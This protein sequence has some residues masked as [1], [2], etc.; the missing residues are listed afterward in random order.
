MSLFLY[1]LSLLVISVL[2]QF[3]YKITFSSPNQ[4]EDRIIDLPRGVY[5]PIT[6]EII[7]VDQ[8]ISTPTMLDLTTTDPRFHL[9]DS[10][11]KITTEETRLVTTFLGIRC[12]TEFTEEE[13]HGG[14]T[15]GITDVNS[16]ICDYEKQTINV[17][18]AQNEFEVV[19]SSVSI[20]KLGFGVFTLAKSL[21]FTDTIEVAFEHDVQHGSFHIDGPMTIFPHYHPDTYTNIMTKY[22][23]DSKDIDYTQIHITLSIANKNVEKCYKLSDRSTSF[24]VL[25]ED[26]STP[27]NTKGKTIPLWFSTESTNDNS[28]YVHSINNKTIIDTLLSCVITDNSYPYPSTADILAQNYTLNND[29]MRFFRLFFGD[30]VYN[31]KYEFNTLNRYIQYKY[32]CA[33]ENNR[34]NTSE[35][36]S[37]DFFGSRRSINLID[38]IEYKAQCLEFNFSSIENENEFQEKLQTFTYTMLYRNESSFVENSC[39][40]VRYNSFESYYQEASGHIALL[41]IYPAGQCRYLLNNE[42][43][44]KNI[45]DVFTS[46]KDKDNLKAKLQLKSEVTFNA[47]TDIDYPGNSNETMINVRL[48]ENNKDYIIVDMEMKTSNVRS[49]FKCEYELS[50]FKGDDPFYFKF[51]PEGQPAVIM[52]S[53]DY[54]IHND[55]HIPYPEGTENKLHS[56]N[57]KCSYFPDIR[58]LNSSSYSFSYM[59]IMRNESTYFNC[60]NEE[61]KKT[62]AYC[63]SNKAN[64]LEYINVHKTPVYVQTLNEDVKAFDKV[65]FEFKE[66]RIKTMLRA[67]QNETNM[68]D[69]LKYLITFEEYLRKYNCIQS[70]NG[71]DLCIANKKEM[72]IKGFEKYRDTIKK[73]EGT[74]I[75]YFKTLDKAQLQDVYYGILM[76]FITMLNNMDSVQDFQSRMLIKQLTAIIEPSRGISELIQE[77]LTEEEKIL[78]KEDL[79]LLLLNFTLGYNDLITHCSRKGLIA[80]DKLDDVY[81]QFTT[82]IFENFIVNGKYA[83]NSEKYIF[84]YETNTTTI[85]SNSNIKIN[86]EVLDKETQDAMGIVGYSFVAYNEFEAFLNEAN[87]SS[88]ADLMISVKPFFNNNTLNKY[89]L[90]IINNKTIKL[91]FDLSQVNDV[92]RFNTCYSVMYNGSLYTDN[93]KTIYDSKK[94]QLTCTSTMFADFIIGTGTVSPPEPIPPEDN[95]PKS[96]LFRV[97]MIALLIIVIVIA[98]IVVIVK[99]LKNKGEGNELHSFSGSRGDLKLIPSFES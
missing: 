4:R 97:I 48:Q 19:L 69:L 12:D 11:I 55:I 79:T 43:V 58:D 63:L 41:C 89:E 54:K 21:Y 65:L 14:I 98:I 84:K 44:D 29:E 6:I 75:D 61:D 92:N 5:T 87:R 17:T 64:T 37:V 34:L 46:L 1:I 83:I 51:Y 18:D 35:G 31:F 95:D 15:I 94:M 88:V 9:S 22:Y 85:E 25:V 59:F 26:D 33:L 77:T 73:V 57:F 49:P 27:I 66:E 36:Y 52:F 2:S 80:D 74:Y 50:E 40:N 8:S 20:P 45:E 24:L 10:P 39:L 99:A 90:P 30:D 67:A 53:K 76:Y 42:T 23:I 13:L 86:I 28:V 93:I 91:T 62:N 38:A 96:T 82:Q 70:K 71:F 68:I 32:K 56:L 16:G 60:E 78:F 7:A 72:Q 81:L 47:I 3:Q